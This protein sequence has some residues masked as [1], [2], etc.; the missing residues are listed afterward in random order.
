MTAR[1]AVRSIFK[2]LPQTL[3]LQASGGHGGAC[4][5]PAWGCFQLLPGPENMLHSVVMSS[6]SLERFKPTMVPLSQVT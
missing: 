2:R 6:P 5:N 4:F 3:P 1:R